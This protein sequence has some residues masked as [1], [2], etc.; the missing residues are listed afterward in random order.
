MILEMRTNRYVPGATP[1]VNAAYEK[2]LPARAEL[3]TFGGLFHVDV[4]VLNTSIELWPYA[5]EQ[6]RATVL[7]KAGELAEWPPALEEVKIAEETIVLQ[8]APSNEEFR[9][10]EFGKIYE[11]RIYQVVPGSMAR[12][13][14]NWGDRIAERA[15]M[16][17]FLGL[18]YN[19]SERSQAFVHIWAYADGAERQAIRAEAQARGIWPPHLSSEGLLVR[20]ESIIAIPAPFSPLH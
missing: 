9:V 19:D 1:K 10:G 2:A 5:D 7:A 8:P 15:K 18:Y 14:K 13:L 4:G 6:A 20:Q 3:S 12:A 11:F 17:P 16:S